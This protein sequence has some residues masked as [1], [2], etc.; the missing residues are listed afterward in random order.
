MVVADPPLPSPA[1]TAGAAATRR[2][3]RL[4]QIAG[5]LSRKKINVRNLF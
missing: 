1:A 2:I 3:A 5:R 4:P